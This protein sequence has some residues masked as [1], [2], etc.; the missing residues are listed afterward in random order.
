MSRSAL[1]VYT[2][3]EKATKSGRQLE[4][5]AL[6][7]SARLLQRCQ[8]LWDTEGHEARL[9][10]ALKK[11]QML[12]TFFQAELADDANPLPLEIR[13][14]LLNLSRFVDR[15]TFDVMAFPA[16]DKLGVLINI[17]RN[18]AAG[19][20]GPGAAVEAEAELASR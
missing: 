20:S 6:T 4:A 3:A 2:S 19:L 13:K 15:R 1:D 18:I 8:E 14:N 5:Y 17:N 16:A 11:N 10:E 12:W 7:Q 9:D